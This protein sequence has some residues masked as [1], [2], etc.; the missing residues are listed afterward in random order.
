MCTVFP[1]Q[2]GGVKWSKIDHITE[3]TV[4][5]HVRRVRKKLEPLAGDPIETVY[6][7]GY[8]FTDA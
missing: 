8:R 5:S 1:D 6:G 7:V 4:D 2:L 3:R